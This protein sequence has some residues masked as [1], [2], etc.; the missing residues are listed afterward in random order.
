M[1]PSTSQQ[2]PSK[3]KTVSDLHRDVNLFG[4]PYRSPSPLLY[5]QLASAEAS[6][7]N[8]RYHIGERTDL[9]RSEILDLREFFNTPS[10][11]GG[12]DM[13]YFKRL[14]TRRVKEMINIFVDYLQQNYEETK[15]LPPFPSIF[16]KTIVDVSVECLYRYYLITNNS[17]IYTAIHDCVKVFYPVPFTHF[18]IPAELNSNEEFWKTPV[19]NETLRNLSTTP[20]RD[21]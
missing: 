13:V 7:E 2:P 16:H 4:V 3:P 14:C 9:T 18:V 20:F 15:V 19:Q 8:I 5:Y 6:N 21:Y 17:N 12:G 10:L 1:Q 11:I